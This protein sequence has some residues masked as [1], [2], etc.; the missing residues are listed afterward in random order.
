MTLTG[1]REAAVRLILIAAAVALGVGLVLIS[2]AG[3]NA[4]NT[5]NARYAWLG[6]GGGG[7]SSTGPANSSATGKTSAADPLWWLLQADHFDGQT[8]ARVDLAAT[9]PRSPVPP[10]IPRLPGPGQFYASPALSALLH[11][12]PAG[13][14]G[15]RF[16]G[17]QIGAIGAAALPA[18]NSLVIIIGHTAGQLS[19]VPGAVKVTSISPITPSSCGGSDCAIVG[20]INSSG[21][22]LVLSVITAAL[23]FPVLIFIGTAT[24]LSAARR[25]QRFAAIRL[26]GATPRQVSVISAVESTVAAVAGVA[27]GFGLFFLLRTPLAA[28]PFT[29]APFFPSDLSL[30]PVDILAVA[31]GVPVAA[32][33]AALL[34]LRRVQISPLGVTRRVTPRPPR[35]WRLVPLLAGLAELAYFVAAGHPKTIGGQVQAFLPGF[36]LI[37]AGL[38]I[39]GPWL[40]MTG[41]RLM[42]R[43]ARRPA[44]LIAARRLAD[45]PRAGFR[46]VSG[47]VLALFVTTVAVGVI[48]TIIANRG[49]P[50]GGTAASDTLTTQLG[51]GPGEA[52]SISGRPASAPVSSAL[53]TRLHA[54]QGVRAVTLIHTDP[55]GIT[56]PDAKL[57]LPSSLA[58]MPAGLISCAQLSRFPLLGRC[59]AGAQAAGIPPAGIVDWQRSQASTV[60]P[61]AAITAQR[62]E[63]LPVQAI[64]VGTNGSTQAI[65]RARTVL[66]LAYPNLAA[67]PATIGDLSA[68]GGRVSLEYEQLAQVVILV[69]LPIAGCTLAVS[70]AAGLTDRKRPFSLLRLTG[71]PLGVLRRVVALESAAPLLITAVLSTGLGFLAAGLFL[72]AQMGYSLRPPGPEYYVIVLAGLVASLGIIA[73]TLPVLNRITGPETARNE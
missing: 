1:G 65:E 25:E 62:L 35:A 13:E 64:F 60:W 39:A 2:L 58:P 21:I 46:A 31:L 28:L 26:V 20:G 24:R 43:H 30:S 12:T 59:P 72:S 6:T 22:D 61:A 68:Q 69:S 19:R 18:P 23:L 15:D 51:Y 11:S 33:A 8:I 49:A 3:I 44:T 63:R 73:S 66:E 56:I 54:I 32:S 17:H 27:V 7:T 37:M 42:A 50:S 29:G 36:L 53:L 48:T 52:I 40:T 47:L 71:A 10:G 38:V 14:L 4:V 55:L 5:Q 34:A 57:G 41:A 67:A 9:G 70:V 45:N 16:P